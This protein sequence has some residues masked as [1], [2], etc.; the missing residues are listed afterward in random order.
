MNSSEEQTQ[1]VES[2]PGIPQA[3]QQLPSNVMQLSDKMILLT[4]L[5]FAI[6]AVS[7]HKLLW[8]PLLGALDSREKSISTALEGAE[9]ARQ[10]I[11]ASEGRGAEIVA[12]AN[13]KARL[14]AERAARD[15]T[16][17]M[18]RADSEIAMMTQ[19]RIEAAEESIRAEQRKAFEM[20]RREAAQQMIDSIETFVRSELTDEQKRAYQESMLQEVRL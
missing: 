2:V 16:A 20:V 19:R 10:E 18:A 12:A 11:A 4:W 13:E 8:K 17:A 14:T 6:A 3:L 9:Q 5:A 1:A 7:L 15:A